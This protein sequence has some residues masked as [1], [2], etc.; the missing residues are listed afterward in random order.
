[1]GS[2]VYTAIMA[3]VTFELDEKVRRALKQAAINMNLPEKEIHE[4][5]LREY[6]GLDILN[7]L[8]KRP[9]LLTEEEAAELANA[10]LHAMR[11]E[12]EAS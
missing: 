11:R 8:R 12:R 2:W 7:R 9:T 10:E 3:K 6:L 5:A 4:R 1:M